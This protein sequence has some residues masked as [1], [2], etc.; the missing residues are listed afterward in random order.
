MNGGRVAGCGVEGGSAY[1]R[2]GW[3]SP[4][5]RFFF[6]FQANVL[7]MKVQGVYENLKLWSSTN[8][9]FYVY[10]KTLRN[11]SLAKYLTTCSIQ[12]KQFNVTPQ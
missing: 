6:N 5:A 1:S 8:L 3:I 11:G 7:H 2:L 10:L 12:Q 4:A 9:S